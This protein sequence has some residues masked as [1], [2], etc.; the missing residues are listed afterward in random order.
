MQVTQATS[1]PRRGYVLFQILLAV[2]TRL[3]VMRA[4]DMHARAAQKITARRVDRVTDHP[5]IIELVTMNDV[6]LAQIPLNHWRR[7]RKSPYQEGR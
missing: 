7:L 2:L 6:E 1:G 3:M 5:A 4:D